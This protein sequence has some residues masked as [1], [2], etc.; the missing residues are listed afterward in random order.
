MFSEV[1]SEGN[2]TNEYKY[3]K[4][5]NMISDANK[6]ISSVSYNYLNLPERV[7]TSEGTVHYTY[8]ATGTKLKKFYDKTSGSDEIT[9]YLGGIQYKDGVLDF[10]QHSEGRAR[11][12]GSSFAYEYNLTDHL[13]NVR[14]TIDA[15]GA[16]VQRDDYY[17][18]GLTFNS[19]KGS[20]KNLYTYN[21]KEEQEETGWLDYHARMYDPSLMRFMTIDPSAEN[22]LEWTPYN[23]VGNNPINVID[24][25][26]K[27]WYDINGKIRWRN[28]EGDYTNKKG[29]E[30]KSLG[31]NVLVGTH[32]RD[33]DG[34]ED[35]NTASFSLYLESNK[36]GATAT[37][38]G[39]TVPAD[40]ENMNT[41][42]EGTYE[43]EQWDY[44]Q[45]DGTTQSRFIVF[46]RNEDGSVNL[47]LPTTDGGTMSEVYFHAGNT[48][49]ESLTMNSGDPISK[50]CQCGPSGD[51]SY[52]R[53]KSFMSNW[54]VT[55]NKGKYYLRSK[56]DTPV[57]SRKTMKTHIMVRNPNGGMMLV[58]KKR[59]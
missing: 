15:A 31:K 18:G 25:D 33:K 55:P 12:N 28:K 26:G 58:P 41:L 40:T 42:A 17:P 39:N 23:Y 46:Q 24:P 36:S 50:G 7:S 4:N 54:D 32:N 13:G 57:K 14:V 56:P 45:K 5:G 30:F 11:K 59:K 29:K 3:D 10:I 53:Y 51:G 6:A 19:M 37:I 22:Y 16:V 47:N 9:E 35:V 38:E 34:N 20:P 27:D 48:A 44:K 43:M 52:S 8:D 2:V 49:R 21:G 1:Y